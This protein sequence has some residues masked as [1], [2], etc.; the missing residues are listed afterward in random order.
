MAP[1][2]AIAEKEEEE[3][4]RSPPKRRKAKEGLVDH[5][6]SHTVRVDGTDW[7][8]A[9]EWVTKMG[10]Y[11]D[12]KRKLTQSITFKCVLKAA[13]CGPQ[14]FHLNEGNKERQELVLP[15]PVSA[16]ELRALPAR[17]GS[18]RTDLQLLDAAKHL[19]AIADSLER[20]TE[21]ELI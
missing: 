8:T 1:D 20:A 13:M 15:R 16:P 10:L 6:G 3:A 7:A 18:S 14:P 4:E 5:D 19:R 9:T 2:R 21:A 11:P 12:P 17:G